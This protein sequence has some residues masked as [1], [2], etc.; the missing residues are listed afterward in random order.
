MYIKQHHKPINMITQHINKAIVSCFLEEAFGKF[1]GQDMHELVAEKF[2]AHAWAA[3]GLP[4]GPEGVNQFIDFMR[5]SFSNPSVSIEDMIAEGDK[6]V[7]RYVFEADHTG[8][9]MGI[10]PTGNRF[11]LPG[12]LIA[13]LADG[14]LTEYWREEDFHT[15]LQK[16]QTEAIQEV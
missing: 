5:S 2:H 14:K 1:N 6:V 4:D 15:A 10:A 8:A 13:R 11:I 16:L 9:L 3:W 12:I 7:V